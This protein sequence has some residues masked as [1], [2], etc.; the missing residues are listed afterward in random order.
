VAAQAPPEP[1][2]SEV[3]E[4]LK[5]LAPTDKDSS[6]RK[7][8]TLLNA[9]VAGA[10]HRLEQRWGVPAHV[11]ILSRE[12]L[13][14]RG[15]RELSDLLDDLPEMD[16]ARHYG[17]DNFKNYWRGYRN[18]QGD[19]YLVLV[20]GHNT[21]DL[22]L[23]IGQHTLAA[24]P[25]SA[26]E[27]V[28]VI[29][30]PTSVLYGAN[31]M[32]GI[33]NI[34]TVANRK[35]DGAHLW[36]SLGVGN[37]GFRT[38]DLTHFTKRG[39]FRARF[40]ARLAEV[41]VDERSS[42][43]YEYTKRKYLA[44][45]RIWAGGFLDHPFLGLAD[46]QKI[47]TRAVDLRVMKADTEFGLLYEQRESGYGVT[48][49]RDQIQA[50]GRWVQPEW[51]LH[52]KHVRALTKTLEST[53]TLRWRRSQFSP[54]TWDLEA[55]FDPHALGPGQGSFLNR[56]SHW[57]VD[58]QATSVHQDFDWWV[59]RRWSLNAGL[60]WED[61][62]LQRAYDYSPEPFRPIS[63]A[64]LP[65]P[66][67][68]STDP[69][70][71][72]RVRDWGTYLQARIRMGD[73]SLLHLG[74]RRDQHPT[75]GSSTNT[76]FAFTGRMGPMGIKLLYGEAFQEPNPRTLYGGFLQAGDN[77]Y[78]KPESSRTYELEFSHSTR[79]LLQTLDV[80]RARYLDTV[81]F[82]QNLGSRTIV[83][84]DYQIQ[85][86]FAPSALDELRVSGFYSRILRA[87]GEPAGDFGLTREGRIGDLS[88][89]KFW[90]EI[91][92]R[93]GAFQVSLRGRY[94]D[95]RPTPASNPVGSVPAQGTLDG[96]FHWQLRQVGLRLSVQNI[97]DRHYFHPGIYKAD[98]GTLPGSFVQDGQGVT[99]W[100]GSG[101]AFDS[102]K[103]FYNSHLPQ[104][105]R[106]LQ[107]SLTMKP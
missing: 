21:N 8:N 25:L 34:V 77:P 97:F 44:D 80:Y 96:S 13:E 81:T 106:T 69:A 73:Q 14:Q 104:P 94:L 49:A 71:K 38:A 22:W 50:Q 62:N 46:P 82:I 52:L 65:A 85:A 33:I 15:Y 2:E 27:R 26:V 102:A 40:S 37:L 23:T 29:Y 35:E 1:P 76:R 28:E 87:V 95:A 103:G 100:L 12:D 61:R 31:A 70:N 54:E 99:H 56:F 86:R 58:S 17:D 84:V 53:T 72:I 4:T 83:G 64:L 24:F 60:R 67:P 89:N 98:A 91:A 20:D 18:A 66:L 78:L 63:V 79:T 105:G 39:D 101:G 30:G 10:S 19:P 107:L 45:R 3:L 36:G 32:V 59:N 5:R 93:K 88:P 55:Y 51:S 57:R 90:A 9:Q 6:E 16:L 43:D 41:E 48:Y 92:A 11:I 68:P 7:P 75:F 74:V 47:Q 42:E